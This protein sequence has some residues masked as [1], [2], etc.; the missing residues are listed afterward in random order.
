MGFEGGMNECSALTVI[1]GL[2]ADWRNRWA[3]MSSG[4]VVLILLPLERT[5]LSRGHYTAF[6]I[7]SFKKFSEDLSVLLLLKIFD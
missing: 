6:E 5:Y 1:F 3:N 4:F 7:Q 2:R